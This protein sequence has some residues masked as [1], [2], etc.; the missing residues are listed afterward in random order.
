MALNRAF[1]LSWDSF[2]PSPEAENRSY[3]SALQ[4]LGSK[5]PIDAAAQVQSNSRVDAARSLIAMV[6]R[7]PTTLKDSSSIFILVAPDDI[8]YGIARVT[9][10]A[11][12][13]RETARKA[14][15]L[16]SDSE[17]LRR[18]LT[19]AEKRLRATERKLK[20]SAASADQG[21]PRHS[22]GNRA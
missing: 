20:K 9:L 13:A 17:R 12:I 2:F 16:K 1:D 21:Q 11:Q 6:L 18:L 14:T 10:A 19:V 15:K 4:N 5:Q 22:R 8:D 3:H 7:S